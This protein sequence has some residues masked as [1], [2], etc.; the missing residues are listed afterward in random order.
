MAEAGDEGAASQWLHAAVQQEPRQVPQ[1]WLLLEEAQR[2][3]KHSGGPH[4]T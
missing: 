1:G 2:R 3:Q 4:E